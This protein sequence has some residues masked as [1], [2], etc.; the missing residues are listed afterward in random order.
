MSEDD[1]EARNVNSQASAAEASD[2]DSDRF[3]QARR[4]KRSHPKTE[5]SVTPEIFNKIMFEAAP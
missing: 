5:V 1:L 2:S 4:P 3:D